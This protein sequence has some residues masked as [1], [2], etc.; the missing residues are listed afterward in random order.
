MSAEN[1][2][3]MTGLKQGCLLSPILFS[4]LIDDLAKEIKNLNIGVEI[5]NTLLNILL[6]ADD[7][8]ILASTP[9][10]LQLMLDTIHMWLKNWRLT[11]NGKKSKVVHFRPS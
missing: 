9:E 6:Y 3:Q 4:I 8:A 2:V 5:G 10:E 7:I 1:N 11:L